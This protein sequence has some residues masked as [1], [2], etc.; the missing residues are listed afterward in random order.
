MT[1]VMFKLVGFSQFKLMGL[2]NVEFCLGHPVGI[3]PISNS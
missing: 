2:V 1:L 3:E